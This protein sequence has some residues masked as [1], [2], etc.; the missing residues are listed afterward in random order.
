MQKSLVFC[1]GCLSV[2]SE[3]HK[4]QIALF[5]TIIFYSEILNYLRER[6]CILLSV[7]LCT[8]FSTC[9]PK[10]FSK[11]SITFLL[12]HWIIELFI[13]PTLVKHADPFCSLVLCRENLKQ[14]LIIPKCFTAYIKPKCQWF[15]D[16]SYHLNFVPWTFR[17]KSGRKL[18]SCSKIVYC[19]FERIWDPE[20][21]RNKLNAFNFCLSLNDLWIAEKIWECVLIGFQPEME[22][23]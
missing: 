20:I 8:Y 5:H 15:Y 23:H 12:N 14:S 19:L 13:L 3:T 7:W 10:S 22:T 2:L 21:E 16:F 1:Q 9:R 6:R 4:A 18:Q 17:K 11:K